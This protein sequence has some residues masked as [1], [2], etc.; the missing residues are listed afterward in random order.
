MPIGARI[1]AAEA[2]TRFLEGE[3]AFLPELKGEP[4]LVALT[5]AGG[6]GQDEMST[7]QILSVFQRSAQ[8]TGF[9]PGSGGVNNLRRGV[10]VGVQK[11]AERAGFDPAMHA[12]KVVNHR[13]SGHGCREAVCT[14]TRWQRRM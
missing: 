2:V 13:Q 4:L 5:R 3:K 8:Q 14:R 1:D 6:F 10:M 11:G 12:K 9:K 7:K